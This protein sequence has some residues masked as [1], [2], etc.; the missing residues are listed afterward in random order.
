M[1]TLQAHIRFA[2]TTTISEK[3]NKALP[4]RKT[5]F[6]RIPVVNCR[7]ISEICVGLKWSVGLKEDLKWS[8]TQLKPRAVVLKI[9]T[10]DKISESEQSP[11]NAVANVKCTQLTKHVL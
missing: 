10:S 3:A 6:V 4:L 2:S 11:F 7:P 9:S 1:S 5:V 8:G